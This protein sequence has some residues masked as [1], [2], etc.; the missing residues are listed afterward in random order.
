MALRRPGGLRWRQGREPL[1]KIP[2]ALKKAPGKSTPHPQTKEKDMFS[3]RKKNSQEKQKKKLM[4]QLKNF[5]CPYQH[6]L[7]G[8]VKGG[9]G[10]V[11]TEAQDN[12]YNARTHI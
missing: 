9:V 10:F 3:C 4:E 11:Y 8:G 7:G 2:M 1:S 6:L 12:W 5:K